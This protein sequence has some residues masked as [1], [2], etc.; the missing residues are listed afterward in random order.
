MN[1]TKTILLLA[2]G[3]ALALAWAC[4]GSTASNGNGGDDGG[5]SGSSSGASGSSSGASGS[6]SGTGGSSGAGSSSGTGSS[7][8]AGSSSGSSS[9]GGVPMPYMCNGQ[10]CTAPNTCCTVTNMNG[11]TLTCESPSMCADAGGR[12]IE[13]T[14]KANCPSGDYC[15]GRAGGAGGGSTTCEATCGMGSAALCD[16]ANGNA[17]CPMGD[18]CR[19][20]MGGMTGICLPMR[21]GGGPPMDAG[22]GGG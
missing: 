15:C 19:T 12:S 3:G 8:G 14:S 16:P 13:C 18:Q 11:S 22:G 20:A 4:G 9:S 7:S 1:K 6:S 17:D 5:S 21:D 2:A 10:P